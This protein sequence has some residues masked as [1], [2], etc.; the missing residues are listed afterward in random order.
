[1]SEKQDAFVDLVRVKRNQGHG[2]DTHIE[3]NEE[4]IWRILS[5]LIEFSAPADDVT[6][7]GT[8]DG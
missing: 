5:F 7:E 8:L 1:M 4:A 2:Y 6:E 3:V